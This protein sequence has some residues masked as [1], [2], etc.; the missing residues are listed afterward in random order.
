MVGLNNLH[1][2]KDMFG[3]KDNVESL[4][5]NGNFEGVSQEQMIKFLETN[6]SKINVEEMTKFKSVN[7]DVFDE[8]EPLNHK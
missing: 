3:A 4:L 5:L 8:V 1:I 7:Q 2:A 6:L